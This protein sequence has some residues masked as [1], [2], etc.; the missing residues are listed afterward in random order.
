MDKKKLTIPAMRVRKEAGEKFIMVTAYDYPSA[1]LVDKTDIETILVGDSLGMTMLGYDSTVPVTMDEMI[2]HIKPVVKG[3]PNCFVVG[4]MPFG[5]YQ[6]GIEEAVKNGVR[7][8]KEGGADAVKLEGGESMADTV[9]ALVQA[10]IPVMA[11]IGLTPQTVSQLGGYRVQGKDAEGA[12]KLLQDALVL[13]EAGAFGIVLECVPAP[14]AKLISERLS[15]PT[16]GIGAGPDCD[17]QVLVY[18]DLLGLFERFLPKFVKQYANLGEVI[19][20]ALSSYAGDVRDGKFPGPEHSFSMAEEE[21]EKVY[22]ETLID[23]KD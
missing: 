7:M 18:H 12:R 3:A 4:D 9:Q 8:L 15:I 22:G 11:H 21:V 16:V 10:G 2:H 14:I 1:V 6:T 5:S 20:Q 17:A 23:L 13:E 19:V